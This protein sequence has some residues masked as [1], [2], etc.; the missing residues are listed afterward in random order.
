VADYHILVF[1]S[2][3]CEGDG[4]SKNCYQ[5]K[6]A[7][8]GI[9]KRRPAERQEIFYSMQK[10]KKEAGAQRNGNQRADETEMPR[11]GH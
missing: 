5:P 4:R 9:D 11:W 10:E 6:L 8:E 3:I 2:V 7:T 1:F